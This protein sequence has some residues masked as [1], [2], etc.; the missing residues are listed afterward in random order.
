VEGAGVELRLS[1]PGL[2]GL[3]SQAVWGP[4]RAEEA[5]LRVLQEIG[6]AR[7]AEIHRKLVE[8]RYTRTKQYTHKI[9]T[10]LPPL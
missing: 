9:L 7:L 8:K 5:V 1:G 6:P 10:K 2:R 4:S 3:V